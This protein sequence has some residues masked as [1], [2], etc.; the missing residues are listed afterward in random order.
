MR[1]TQNYPVPVYGFSGNYQRLVLLA[2][3]QRMIDKGSAT[4]TT[5]NHGRIA[6]IDVIN[7][8]SDER[9]RTGTPLSIASYAGKPTTYRDVRDRVPG[10]VVTPR[11][12]NSRDA[13]IYRLS[14]TDC[15]APWR[16]DAA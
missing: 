10:G 6:R 1:V 8:L 14:V 13:D 2:Q 3:A 15:L 4:A 12:I 9:R 16:G 5:G 7:R 11:H